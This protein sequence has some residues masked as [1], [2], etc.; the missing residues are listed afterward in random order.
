MAPISAHARQSPAYP[1]SLN[2]VQSNQASFNQYTANQNPS[3]PVSANQSPSS[4][5]SVNQNQSSQI[6]IN[7]LCG[8]DV[9]EVRERSVVPSP[10]QSVIIQEDPRVGKLLC[11]N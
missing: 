4:H 3:N 8:G 5:V 1:A 6:F 10:V 9:S 11:M 7:H 2:Q